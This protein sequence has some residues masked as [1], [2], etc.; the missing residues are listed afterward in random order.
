MMEEKALTCIQSHSRD[1]AP[2]GTFWHVKK[3]PWHHCSTSSSSSLSLWSWIKHWFSLPDLWP[4]LAR[5]HQPPP[6]RVTDRPPS[7]TCLL[8]HSAIHKL[9]NWLASL[10][11]DY[12]DRQWSN[13]HACLHTESHVAASPREGSAQIRNWEL[14]WVSSGRPPAVET[15]WTVC[16]SGP[17]ITFFNTLKRPSLWTLRF[18]PTIQ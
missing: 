9:S 2:P 17:N 13:P 11:S 7:N 1:V 3:N 5:M 18:I 12:Q 10:C 6:H 14:L 8:S 15:S 16:S 4:S